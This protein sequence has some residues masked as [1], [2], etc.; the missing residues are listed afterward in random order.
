LARARA[1]LRGYTCAARFRQGSGG[2]QIQ[3]CVTKKDAESLAEVA[4]RFADNTILYKGL[5]VPGRELF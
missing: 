5:S 3:F 4:K 1:I 2:T